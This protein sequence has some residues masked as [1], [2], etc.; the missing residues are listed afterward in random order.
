MSESV[1]II[2]GGPVGLTA[3][4][5]LA[6][7]GVRTTLIERDVVPRARLRAVA[8]DD[9]CLRIWQRCGLEERIV[10]AWDGGAGDQVMCR[11]L[12]PR[13][14]TFLRLEQRES[15]LGYPHAVAINEARLTPILRDAA[16]Q[17]DQITIRTGRTV[18][19]VEQDERGVRVHQRDADGAFICDSATWAIACD[20]GEST[21]RGA[22]GITMDGAVCPEPWLVANLVDDDPLDHAR[23]TCDPAGAHVT[24]SL[25]HGV[26][27]IECRID[28]ADV[29]AIRQ[30]EAAARTVLCRAWDGA[31]DAPIIDHVVLRFS[32]R[33][34][35]RWRC[36]R[37]FLAGDAAHTT[38]PFAGQGL[39]TGLRDVANL[40]FK[41]AG[42][43]HRWL[44]PAVLWTYEQERRPH[45]E[46]MLHLAR[47]L[48]RMMMPTS[49]SRAWWVQTALRAATRSAAVRRA[50]A[51]RGE[52]IRPVYRDGFVGAGPMAGHCLP[53][54]WVSTHGARRTRI[55]AL[56]G[57]RMTWIAIGHG[58]R[59]ATFRGLALARDDTVLIE[60]RDFVDADRRLQRTFGAECAVLV[61]PDRVVHSHLPISMAHSAAQRTSPWLNAQRQ[62]PR[63]ASDASP[64]PALRV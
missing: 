36:G 35:Q 51:L 38:P 37:V 14:R 31:L 24:M 3:A 13:G 52:S 39:G 10:T 16:A 48:G 53:Q 28:D 42:V 7:H 12:T 60:N 6:Q 1:A 41:L 59:A 9:E 49:R 62:R 26:R 55:D 20:G 40:S 63:G 34:A 5:L 47:R 56:L 17:H 19:G 30:D 33:I 11:Y 15:D 54:P 43:M 57:P 32:S 21:V 25:P 22:L 23:I 50:I 58:A 18:T 27:R 61:R 44:D 2:G 8:L 46:R 45:Q 29:D 64:A 4:L